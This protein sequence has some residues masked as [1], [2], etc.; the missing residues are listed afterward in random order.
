MDRKPDD[1][2]GM[3]AE[4]GKEYVFH[5]ISTLKMT[6]K[7]LQSLSEEYA[8]WTNRAKLA[9]AQG[10]ADLAEEAQ[11]EAARIYARMEAL[12]GE[13]EELKAM[14]ERM[15]RQLPGLAARER[16][17]DPD[18]LE[19]EFQLLLGKSLEE[20]QQEKNFA[21]LEADAAASAA[22]EALKAKMKQEK[23]GEEK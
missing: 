10:K 6:E 11:G 13:A 15:R 8:K 5:H 14:I 12:A 9:E 19:Q 2:F 23:T 3:T 20:M 7:E 16:S 21:A 18:V 17:V 4:A 1:L 22:L